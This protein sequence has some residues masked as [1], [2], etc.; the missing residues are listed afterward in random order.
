MWDYFDLALIAA[1]ALHL[2]TNYG[3]YEDME[4]LETWKKAI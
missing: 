2:V 1:Y 4:G 3:K